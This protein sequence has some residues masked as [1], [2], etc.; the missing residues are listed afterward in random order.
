MFLYLPDAEPGSE[1]RNCSREWEE[2]QSQTPLSLWLLMR[3]QRQKGSW[4]NQAHRILLTVENCAWEFKGCKI[5]T[6]EIQTKK[7]HSSLDDDILRN[8]EQQRQKIPGLEIP[9]YFTNKNFSKRLILSRKWLLPFYPTSTRPTKELLLPSWLEDY[10][11]IEFPISGGEGRP[12]S[13][14]TDL[15]HRHA[16]GAAF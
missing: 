4:G 6:V 11:A 15:G 7:T 16:L 8:T 1:E 13:K 10:S 14:F 2:I 3:S 12:M 5:L 9:R